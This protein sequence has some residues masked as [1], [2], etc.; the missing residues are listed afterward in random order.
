MSS[1]CNKNDTTY[2]EKYLEENLPINFGKISKENS[3]DKENL[4][5]FI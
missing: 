2:T 4:F 3:L 5:T 1:V